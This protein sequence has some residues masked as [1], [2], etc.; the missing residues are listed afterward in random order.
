V[1]VV[2]DD[3]LVRMVARHY[4]E[5]VGFTAFEAERA[6]EALDWLEGLDAAKTC[7]LIADVGLPD[8][9]GPELVREARARHAATTAVLVSAH[10]P[11]LLRERGMV[12]RGQRVLHKPFNFEELR[13]AMRDVLAEWSRLRS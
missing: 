7:L 5:R 6:D 11:E 1:L 8:M 10:S 9:D 3:P 4:V 12:E 2:D 13:D